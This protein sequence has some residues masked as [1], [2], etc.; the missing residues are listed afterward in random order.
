MTSA[1][2]KLVNIALV[3]LA[4]TGALKL[5]SGAGDTRILDVP[6]Q[7]LGIPFR[8]VFFIVGSAELLAGALFLHPRL[9][10]FA[11]AVLLSFSLSFLSYRVIS[12]LFSI[13]SFC[14]C[15][16]R[17][18]EWWPWLAAHQQS[19]TASIALWFGIVGLGAMFSTQISRHFQDT[20]C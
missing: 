4:V 11:P 8:K 10:R 13:N 6:D 9:R 15:L 7:L 3:T 20:Y 12:A 1:F 16:G 17:A 5:I 19:A 18:A 14:P 2:G